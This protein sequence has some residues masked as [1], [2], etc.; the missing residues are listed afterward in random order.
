[1]LFMNILPD[2]EKYSRGVPQSNRYAPKFEVTKIFKNIRFTLDKIPIIIN[3]R[4]NL[5]LSDGSVLYFGKNASF[6]L[7]CFCL[8]Y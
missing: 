4:H 3:L 2:T 5:I 1:M 8:I 7:L 6:G